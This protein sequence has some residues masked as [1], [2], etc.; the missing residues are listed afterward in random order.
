MIVSRNKDTQ[1]MPTPIERRRSRFLKAL[2]AANQSQNA[3]AKDNGVSKAHL[4][5]VLA[6]KRD[7]A[8]L[9]E[10]IDA[11]I[12]EHANRRVTAQAS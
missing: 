10:R 6:G 2:A 12:A 3:W 1:T 5:L 8:S 9:A 11:F 7:S 4:S